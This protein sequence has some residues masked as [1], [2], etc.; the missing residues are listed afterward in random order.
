MQAA[1]ETETLGTVTPTTASELEIVPVTLEVLIG[2]GYHLFQSHSQEVDNKDVALD[3][4]RYRQLEGKQVLMCLGAYIG[5]YMIGYST[6]I[7]YRHGHHDTLI[8]SNDSIYVDPDFRTG[9]GL[10]LIRQTEKHA[11]ECGVDCMVWAAK[12]GSS[13]DLILAARRNCKLSQHYYKV[14]F[15][16]Q[17]QRQ[18]SRS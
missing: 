10:S 8:A 3:L 5:T 1:K 12:P 18:H 7:F 2:D 17:S 9:A 15:D 4:D 16:G 11:Q 6:T 13:L 14:S